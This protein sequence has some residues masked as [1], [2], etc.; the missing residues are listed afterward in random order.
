MTLAKRL[1]DRG[2]KKGLEMGKADV[3]WKQMIKKFPNLQAAYLDK[4][5]QLD[6]IRLDILALE[7]LD[8]QSEEE[9]K[10]HLPM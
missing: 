4:L 5:K 1:I 3:I 8:I 9:L 2:M 10:N 6:E 7:L